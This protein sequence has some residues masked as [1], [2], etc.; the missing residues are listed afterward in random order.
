M[1]SV[2][3][4]S[5]QS[6]HGQPSWRLTGPNVET[7]VTE[8]GG[9]LG[10][11]TFRLGDRNLHP[12]A[13]AP[14]AEEPATGHLLPVLRALRGDFFCLPF[15]GNASSFNGEVHPPHGETANERWTFDGAQREGDAVSLRL[16]LD[17]AARKGRVRKEIT[18]VDGHTALYQ[19][20]SV[21]GMTGPM[22]LGHQA[23]LRCPDA[24]GS[25]LLAT[26]PFVLGRTSPVPLEDPARG[27][28]SVL[29]PDASFEALDA[30]PTVAGSQADL[31]RFPARRGY[32]DLVA[33]AS[34]PTLPLA[35]TAV[36]FPEAGF[37]WFAL[38]DPGVLRQTVLWFSN[39]GRH[40]APWSGRHAGVLG[41][42]D[43]TAYFHLGL[44]ES[45][46]SNP[47]SEQGIPTYVSLAGGPFRVACIHAVARVPAMFDHVAEVYAHDGED[48][49]TLTSR[50]GA[51]VRVPLR[52][53]FLRAAA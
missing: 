1:E 43:A 14:W 19:R 50:S 5:L 2:L 36:T 20:H 9:H 3:H 33:L 41:L 11:T 44:A 27:G 6:V 49:V 4:G 29:A 10:P 34:D 37:V 31:S 21:T 51:L 25:G 22:S 53:R 28:Y 32:D 48:A 39:G 24:E 15:G 38:R 52:H 17:P 40:Y 47:L 46:A 13:V 26:S 23:M 30:V 35:W 16:R 18:L 7:F 45:A 8:Q 42:A 12:Y